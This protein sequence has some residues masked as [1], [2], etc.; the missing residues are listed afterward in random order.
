MGG[1]ASIAIVTLQPMNQAPMNLAIVVLHSPPELAKWILS[2]ILMPQYG[3]FRIDGGVG[4][5]HGTMMTG[6]VRGQFGT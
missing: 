6:G 5:W 3:T 4:E 2:T 1:I